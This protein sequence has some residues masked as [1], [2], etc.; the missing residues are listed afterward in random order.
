MPRRGLAR[1]YEGP[2]EER[3]HLRPAG[4]QRVGRRQFLKFTG[5][6]L[7][8][9]AAGLALDACS[10]SSSQTTATTV[11]P[12]VASKGRPKY[13]GTIIA[14]VV[15]GGSGDTIDPFNADNPVDYARFLQIYEPFTEFDAKG[16]LRLVLLDELTPNKDASMWTMR[17]REGVT[18][19][20]GKPL[21]ADDLLYT[22][23]YITNPKTASIGTGQ[24]APLDV[25]NARKVD[26]LTLEVPTHFP[27]GLLPQFMADFSIYVVPD[28]WLPMPHQLPNGTGPYIY[29][30][31]TPGVQSLFTRNPDYWI[32]GL[33]YSDA[34]VVDDYSDITSQ[35][36]ALLAGNVDACNYI[37]PEVLPELRGSS[38]AK[39]TVAQS[40]AFTP[41]TMRVDQVPFNDVRVRQ[42]FRLIVNRPAFIDAAFSGLAKLGNDL[43]SPFDPLY[44]HSIP[45]RVQDI[46]EAKALLR[47]AGYHGN[48]EVTLTTAS[49]IGPATLQ[50]AEIFAQQATEAD[51]RVNLNKVTSG[52]FYGSNYLSW[53]FAQDIWDYA[54]Y[55]LQVS[56]SM[57][58]SPSAEN[59]THYDNP[60]YNRLYDQGIAQPNPDKRRPIVHAMQHIDWT[61]GSYIIPCFIPSIDGLSSRLF[62]DVPSV[63]GLGLN[64]YDFKRMW[65]S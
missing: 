14:G 23:Q 55:L 12:T 11:L 43:W 38:K 60:A 17:A 4:P 49:G 46:D 27:F 39:Y 37:S 7:G 22:L 32:H 10:A 40:G 20:N 63:D 50:Q 53:T 52:E 26:S 41:F 61:A 42:A 56:L 24:L 57:V 62:G 64:N 29:K 2:W 28:G 48:L 54:D 35:V 18:F 16:Q 1:A 31:F 3:A 36:E 58:P 51:V 33:P 6:G 34:L 9:F 30:S 45:Q 19:H 15:G 13:G 65:L 59:E 8:L 44:D 21:G 5:A 25:N 47:A